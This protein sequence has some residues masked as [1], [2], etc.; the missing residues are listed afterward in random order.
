MYASFILGSQLF[1]FKFVG[2][3]IV[4]VGKYDLKVD[5]KEL[6]AKISGSPSIRSTLQG[7]FD[8]KDVQTRRELSQVLDSPYLADY[9]H[10][11]HWNYGVDSGSWKEKI[12]PIYPLD[13]MGF[14]LLAKAL[15][16]AQIRSLY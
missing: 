2:P 4:T 5:K 8:T 14:R 11:F 16:V 9:A 15:D 6:L 3:V 7:L 10:C 13:A 1:L 12:D